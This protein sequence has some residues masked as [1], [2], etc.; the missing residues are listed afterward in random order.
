MFGHHYPWVRALWDKDL[1]LVWL[2]HSL[3][4]TPLGVALMP[5]GVCITNTAQKNLYNFW[6][7]DSQNQGAILH[8]L[9]AFDFFS[10]KIFS[11]RNST[12]ESIQVGPTLIW[13]IWTISLFISVS[14]HKSST[15]M[16][17]GKPY[18]EEVARVARESACMFPL[19][20]LC[21]KLKDLNPDC[22]CLTRFKYSCI[23]PSLAFNS[24]FT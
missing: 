18:A 19:L 21:N 9:L 6:S 8:T 7:S 5:Q 11:L 16:T 4:V 15:R 17:W 20:E 3:H 2:P 14:L 22:R 10:S 13:W 24:P 12:M 1:P 23:L